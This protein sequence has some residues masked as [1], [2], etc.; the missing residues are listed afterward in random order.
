MNTTI[1]RL[2][3]SKS[4]PTLFQRSLLKKLE[5]IITACKVSR[6]FFM[7][8]KNS[9]TLQIDVVKSS[10]AM[11][12]HSQSVKIRELCMFIVQALGPTE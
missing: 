6:I 1:Y 5:F 11:P 4:T 2:K 8:P 10:S 7:C 3:V 9:A 12:N